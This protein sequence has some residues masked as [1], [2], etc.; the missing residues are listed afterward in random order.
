MTDKVKQDPREAETDLTSAEVV[1]NNCTNYD[2]EE[3]VHQ[4]IHEAFEAGRLMGNLRY[5]KGTS[6]VIKIKRELRM[7]LLEKHNREMK[8]LQEEIISRVK[9]SVD[10]RKCKGY[11]FHIQK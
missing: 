10:N 6:P 1:D 7:T 2:F 4:C 5:S 11:D 9:T 3:V 8:V